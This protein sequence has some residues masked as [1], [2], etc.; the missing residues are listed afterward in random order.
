MSVRLF[1]LLVLILFATGCV[2]ISTLFKNSHPASLKKGESTMDDVLA[3][4]G[5]PATST[6]NS[7]GTK[8]ITYLYVG[9]KTRQESFIPFMGGFVYDGSKLNNSATVVFDR[10]GRLLD[11][12]VPE[13]EPEGEKEVSAGTAATRTG[14]REAQ[15]EEYDSSRS[16]S[17]YSSH[18]DTSTSGEIAVDKHKLSEAKFYTIDQKKS[19]SV[20]LFLFKSKKPRNTTTETEKTYAEKPVDPFKTMTD[21]FCEKLT[22]YK[23]QLQGLNKEGES[24]LKVAWSSEKCYFLKSEILEFVYILYKTYPGWVE[25]KSVNIERTC[26]SA[27]KKITFSSSQLQSFHASEMNT[28]E[29]FK[30]IE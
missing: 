25:L 3:L 7:D 13:Y 9:S 16:D 29:L 24:V 17:Y 26:N 5:K 4:L 20:D 27:V 15:S 1:C 11:Y 12:T 21:E 23:G 8:T 22:R 30:G 19:K 6:L 14:E 2:S 18:A 10:D 28:I